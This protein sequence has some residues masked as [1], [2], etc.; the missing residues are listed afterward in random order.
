[1]KLLSFLFI[2][3]ALFTATACENGYK[4]SAVT[5]VSANNLP[6]SIENTASPV[7]KEIL[8]KI[9]H[10]PK[11][12][13][14][15]GSAYLL[16]N[17]LP[18]NWMDS[19]DEKGNISPAIYERKM[20]KIIRSYDSIYKAKSITL[21]QF[22]KAKY[23]N[24]R[25]HNDSLFLK[26][27]EKF[28]FNCDYKYRLPNF[29]QYECYYQSLKLTSDYNNMFVRGKR[30]T[31]NYYLEYGNLVFYN[32]VSGKASILNIYSTSTGQERYGSDYKWFYIDSDKKT[33]I[34]EA[35]SDEGGGYF[36]LAQ[37]VIIKP[38]GE[39]VIDNS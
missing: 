17:K 31:D 13:L 27:I 20:T 23:I 24:V 39:I 14:P 38:D 37:T 33:G 3:F 19:T 30:Y 1:M 22:S 32:P 6:S 8:R 25:N 16:K 12:S 11:I 34:Y 15:F 9:S 29:G 2:L 5:S 28:K 36:S 35:G 7:D 21:P 10:L 4:K 18:K 26:D